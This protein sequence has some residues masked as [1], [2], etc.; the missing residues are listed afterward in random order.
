MDLYFHLYIKIHVLFNDL[1]DISQK[2]IF[3]ID[4]LRM[5]IQSLENQH[6]DHN[7]KS[8]FICIEIGT[9]VLFD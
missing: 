6:G 9:G 3:G 8:D 7:A 4:E 1:L 5:W 2:I